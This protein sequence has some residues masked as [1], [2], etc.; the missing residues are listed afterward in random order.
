[1]VG[2]DRDGRWEIQRERQMSQI[3]GL[4]QLTLRGLSSS[5]SRMADLKVRGVA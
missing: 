3:M 4:G 5:Q 2:W 1:M